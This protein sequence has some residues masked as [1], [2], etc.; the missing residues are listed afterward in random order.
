ME[1]INEETS[2]RYPLNLVVKQLLTWRAHWLNACK[3]LGTSVDSIDMAED[4][5]RFDEL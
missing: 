5:E 3:I 4:R 1:I 2:W